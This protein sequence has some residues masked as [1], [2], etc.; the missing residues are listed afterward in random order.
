MTIGTP[1]YAVL[2]SEDQETAPPEAGVCSGTIHSAES[3]LRVVMFGMARGEQLSEDTASCAAI[4]EVVSGALELKLGD[5]V[6]N[7]TSGTWVQMDPG[8]IHAV[9]A[10]TPIVMRLTPLPKRQPKPE[11]SASGDTPS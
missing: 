9:R 7:A 8:L 5:S 1:R 2:T 3:G 10:V 6:V 11:G 4:V